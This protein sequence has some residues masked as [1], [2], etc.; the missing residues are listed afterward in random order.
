MN[1]LWGYFSLFPESMGDTS[2]QYEKCP[3]LKFF[4]L[5]FF[6]FIFSPDT[7]L[8]MKWKIFTPIMYLVIRYLK[9]GLTLYFPSD[10][11]TVAYSYAASKQA[12]RTVRS[13]YRK[14]LSVILCFTSLSEWELWLLTRHNY[15]NQNRASSWPLLSLNK[16]YFG[17][18][19]ANADCHNR[20]NA[21]I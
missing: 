17:S 4:S 20:F 18:N 16:H 3:W 7:Y 21:N 14:C 1:K 12:V 5:Q 19:F 6:F 11:S 10:G 13:G 9:S 15:G 8:Y 2:C